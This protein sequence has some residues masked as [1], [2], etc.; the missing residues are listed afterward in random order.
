MLLE[1]IFL[2]CKN[3]IWQLEFNSTYPKALYEKLLKIK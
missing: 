2:Y 1:I 3:W